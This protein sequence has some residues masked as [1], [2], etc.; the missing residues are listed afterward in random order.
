MTGP[1]RHWAYDVIIDVDAEEGFDLSWPGGT[2]IHIS[3]TLTIKV[4]L[5]G[6]K[7]LRRAL[8]EALQKQ[9]ED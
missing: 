4:S 9:R 6:A 3:K 8:D 7:E 5:D 1:H 2:P